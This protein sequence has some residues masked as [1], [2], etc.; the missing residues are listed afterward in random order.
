MRLKRKI[1]TVPS[2][3]LRSCVGLYMTELVVSDRFR[4]RWQ[5]LWEETWAGSRLQSGIIFALIEWW[6]SQSSEQPFLVFNPV[7][8]CIG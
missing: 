7:C 6:R 4:P 3:R 8:L 5:P 1:V 2:F